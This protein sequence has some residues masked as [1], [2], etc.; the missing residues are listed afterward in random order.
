MQFT[1]A[2]PGAYIW[3]KNGQISAGSCLNATGSWNEG[4]TV[5]SWPANLQWVPGAK[6]PAKPA[7]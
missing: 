1:G 2:G 5:Y 6:A 4:Q 3:V 7:S